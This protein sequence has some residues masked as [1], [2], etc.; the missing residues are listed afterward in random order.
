MIV[1]LIICTLV[2]FASCKFSVLDQQLY[3]N[4]GR[5]ASLD[6]ATDYCGSIGGFMLSF[7]TP[8][9]VKQI[10]NSEVMNPVLPSTEHFYWIDARNTSEGIFKWEQ[11]DRPI[12]DILWAKGEPYCTDDYVCT[13]TIE[14]KGG[15]YAEPDNRIRGVLCKIDLTDGYAKTKLR[16]N[17]DRILDWEDRRGIREIIE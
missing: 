15:L 1:P 17:L 7:L 13:V 10:V 11:T 2:S 16:E 9:L 12:D 8:D 6:E 3:Y 14:S 5:D 4:R